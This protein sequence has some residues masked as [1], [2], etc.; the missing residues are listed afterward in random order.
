MHHRR[1]ILFSFVLACAAVSLAGC[2]VRTGGTPTHTSSYEYAP[3]PPAAP[4]PQAEA[5]PPAPNAQS[6]WVAGHYRW[7]GRAYD[8]QH[9]HYEARP[10]PT[11]QYVQ[12][13]WEQRGNRHYWVDGHWS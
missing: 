5:V 1:P 6:Y 8:W 13:H 4:P 12:G 9:G 3:A 11:A 7:N 10:T 2:Y